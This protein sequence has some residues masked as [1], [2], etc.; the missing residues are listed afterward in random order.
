MKH[1][2]LDLSVLWFKTNAQETNEGPRHRGTK[3]LKAAG[4]LA[5]QTHTHQFRLTDLSDPTVLRR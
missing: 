4:A 1:I 5:R 2:R 3:E